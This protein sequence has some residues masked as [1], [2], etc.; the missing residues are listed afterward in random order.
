MCDLAIRTSR[1]NEDG[2]MR[3]PKKPSQK[4]MKARKSKSNDKHEDSLAASTSLMG[5]SISVLRNGSDLIMPSK[6][7]KHS[8]LENK[9][10]LD[11]IN[12]VK[13]GSMSPGSLSNKLSDGMA[14]MRHSAAYVAKQLYMMPPPDKVLNR[15]CNGQQKVRKMMQMDWKRD[16]DRQK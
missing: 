16:S 4:A 12:G 10:H 15:M 11:H 9:K 8:T 1:L 6:R 5:G 2:M 13:K 3:W 14:E 7:P